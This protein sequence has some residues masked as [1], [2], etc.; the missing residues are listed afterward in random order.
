MKTSIGPRHA[1]PRPVITRRVR[2]YTRRIG[3]ATLLALMMLP[4]I[5][6]F[7][8][9]VSTSFKPA[10]AISDPEFQWLFSPTLDHYVRVFAEN[11]FGRFFRNSLIVAVGST[12]L[13]L[14]M[15]LPAAYV[16]ARRKRT[17]WAA[18]ILVSRITPAIA[19]LI[20]WF[21]L[22]R[23]LGWIDTYQA[24]IATHLIISLPLV[25]WL[26]IGFFE[27]LPSDLIEAALVDGCSEAGAF[28]R[29]AVPL[30]KSGTAASGVLAFLYSWNNFLFS[31]VIA[32]PRTATLPVAVFNFMSYGSL[33][34]GP[35]AAAAVVMTFPVIL[36]VL[37]TQRQIVEGLTRGAV[38]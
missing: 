10:L 8:Y 19:F 1:P 30:A 11:N 29:I 15:G 18:A 35:I 17:G 23:T 31:I 22:F 25:V 38:K 34:F 14:I 20:P 33:N 26:M 28:F 6:F 13:A 16:V 27:D 12:A 37:I 7:W 9:M 32:G 4:I 5:G 21:I 3:F 24:L 36:I 2:H